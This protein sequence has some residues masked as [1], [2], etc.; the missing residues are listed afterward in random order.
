MRPEFS[1]YQQLWGIGCVRAPAGVLPYPVSWRDVDVDARWMQR[2]LGEMG[3]VPGSFVHICHFY[4]DLAQAWPFYQGARNIGAVFANGM[5]TSYDA[6]RLEMYLRRFRLQA[7]IGVTEDT[8]DGL[9]QGGH[10]PAVIYAN[11]AVTA[12]HPGAWERL[13]SF[14]F[15]PWRLRALGP[16]YTVEAPDESG[17]RFDNREWRVQCEDGRLL[18]SAAHQRAAR[19]ERLDTGLRGRLESVKTEAGPELRV[20]VE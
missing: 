10:D 12:A 20:F 3:V 6:Y 11:A 17:G 1:E 15:R 7:A 8:L 14:G 2:Q 13:R 5:P 4:A 9:V 18:L 19:F 16:L